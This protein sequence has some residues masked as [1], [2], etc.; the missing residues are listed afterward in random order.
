[1]PAMHPVRINGDRG[2]IV[3][4]LLGCVVG[5]R[6]CGGIVGGAGGGLLFPLHRDCLARPP[7]PPKIPEDDNLFTLHL[8]LEEGRGFRLGI[9]TS[10]SDNS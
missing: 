9:E 6:G 5:G 7:A 2:T 8:E 3:G 1:M 4:L 10:T